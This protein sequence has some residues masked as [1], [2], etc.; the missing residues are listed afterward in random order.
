MLSWLAAKVGVPWRS[1]YRDISQTHLLLKSC[2]TPRYNVSLVPTPFLQM[3]VFISQTRDGC[4]F[5]FVERLQGVDVVDYLDTHDDGGIRRKGRV[6]DQ[7]QATP[8][9]ASRGLL[10]QILSW[11]A[12]KRELGC[13]LTLSASRI[14]VSTSPALLHISVITL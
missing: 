1:L 9:S 5:R 8:A 4:V 11:K 13:T 14:R 2:H 10:D 7:V 3:A 6:G 12:I